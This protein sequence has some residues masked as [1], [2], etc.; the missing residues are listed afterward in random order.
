MKTSIIM[1]NHDDAIVG[2]IYRESA[3]QNAKI[4]AVIYDS[5]SEPPEL[6]HVC[7]K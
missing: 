7:E 5:F 1:M 2:L 3:V 4:V 6:S